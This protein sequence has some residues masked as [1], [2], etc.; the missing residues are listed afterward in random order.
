MRR[1]LLFTIAFAASCASVPKQTYATFTTPTPLAADDYL[2]IGFLGG[3]EAWNSADQGV[4]KLALQLRAQN[5][6]GLHVETVEEARRTL[7]IELVM[8]AFDRNA[9]GRL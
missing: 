8:R 7:A 6:P 3:M 1:L 2:V 5:I 4:R 9:D